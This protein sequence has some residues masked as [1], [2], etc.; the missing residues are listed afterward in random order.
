VGFV[1]PD[2]DYAT[3]LI[4]VGSDTADMQTHILAFE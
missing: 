2:E 4:S 3:L 1:S